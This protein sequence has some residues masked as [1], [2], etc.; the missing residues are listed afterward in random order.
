MPE[1]RR[2]GPLTKTQRTE[3]EAFVARGKKSAREINRARVLLLAEEGKGASEIARLLGLSRGTVYNGCMKYQAKARR[4][5]GE[6]VPDA[7]RSGRP[8]KLDSRVEAKV[9]RI[10]CSDPPEGRGRWTLHLIADKLVRLGVTASI[11]HESVRTL[12]KKTHL[13]HGSVSSGVL[14]RLP[15]TTS[16]IW[17]TCCTT[18]TCRMTRGIPCSVLMN[19]PVFSLPTGGASGP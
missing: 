11:S 1:R 5:L 6:V 8:I 17:K 4:S 2:K 7:P 16:G 13:S 14:G 15:A 3:L 18:T 19:A 10:A 9:T 12:L